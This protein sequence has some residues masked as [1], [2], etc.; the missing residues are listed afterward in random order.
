MSLQFSANEIL[1]TA[2]RIE[3]N[4]VAFY[5]AASELVSDPKAAELL[6]SL[7]SW[8]VGHVHLF[9]E[10]R[11]GLTDEEKAATVFDPDDQLALYLQSMADRTVFASNMTPG[12][13]FGPEPTLN[14]ILLLAL[15]R[16]KDAVVFYSGI[17]NMVPARLGQDKIDG[18]IR[19]EVSHVV[20]LERQLSSLEA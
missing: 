19:E 11:S 10:M 2:E 13:I 20:M 6:R 18:I 5:A 14:H 7:S 12:E 16:E 9:E 17:R 8:E 4:G 3:R 1:E 15:E